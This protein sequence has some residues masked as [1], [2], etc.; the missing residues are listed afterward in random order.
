MLE[1]WE[2]SIIVDIKR[3]RSLPGIPKILF[4]QI[5]HAM[6]P[7]IADAVTTLQ[8]AQSH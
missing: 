6:A 7:I 5:D 3:K 1:I 2:T 4:R 8:E